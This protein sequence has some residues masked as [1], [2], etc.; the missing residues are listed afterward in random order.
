[1]DI[2]RLL[3]RLRSSFHDPTPAGPNVSAHEH[4]LPLVWAILVVVGSYYILAASIITGVMSKTILEGESA[5]LSNAVIEYATKG[6][7]RYP[8]HAH[9][10]FY[11]GVKVFMLHPL[12]WLRAPVYRGPISPLSAGLT[13]PLCLD[14]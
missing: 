3:E 8:L 10:L 4:R 2:G 9:D 11:P 12:F 1:M 7:L 13:D 5:V 6:E 14:A